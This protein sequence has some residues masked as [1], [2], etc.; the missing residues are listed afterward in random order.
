MKARLG[1]GVVGLIF[2]AYESRNRAH[3]DDRTAVA[4]LDHPVRGGL[5]HEIGAMKVDA[6]R[7]L[8]RLDRHVEK[9][10]EGTNAGVVDEHVDLAELRHGPCDE[11]LRRLWI[12]DV[13]LDRDSAPTQTLDL[14]HC[15]FRAGDVS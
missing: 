4:L 15:R 12:C 9:R 6:H 10:M 14:R 13:A 7:P 3:R 1:R 11:V 2:A 5:A 8:E